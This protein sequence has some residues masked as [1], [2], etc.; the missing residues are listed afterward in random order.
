M[1]ICA[2]ECAP[3]S[4]MGCGPGTAAQATPSEHPTHSTH[5][6]ARAPLLSQHNGA[7]GGR[8]DTETDALNPGSRGQCSPHSH[9]C[10][11]EEE[12]PPVWAPERETPAFG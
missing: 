4:Q 7:A 1:A 6:T 11:Q 8:Q 10:N 12:R 2:T 5:R 9:G 3:K